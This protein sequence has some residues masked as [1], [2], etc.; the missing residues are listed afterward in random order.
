MHLILTFGQKP[1]EKLPKFIVTFQGWITHSPI[2][3]PKQ[4]FL[5]PNWFTL[6]IQHPELIPTL[7]E[8]I[9]EL[10]AVGIKVK[11]D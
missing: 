10:E 1:E 8:D 4:P 2:L 3:F 9:K 6:E 5:Q 11:I 7:E